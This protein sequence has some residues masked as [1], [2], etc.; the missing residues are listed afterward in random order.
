[1]RR[2]AA[3]EYFNLMGGRDDKSDAIEMPPTKFQ[4][5]INMFVERDSLIKRGGYSKRNAAAL[6]GGNAFQAIHEFEDNT[7]SSA[8]IYAV[9]GNLFRDDL[10][11]S[12][13]TD[14]TGGLSLAG[15]Q[16]AQYQ[17]ITYDGEV[18]GTDQTNPL[19]FI[20]SLTSNAASI[21]VGGEAMPTKCGALGLYYQY[22]LAGDVT[23]AEDGV[24]YPYRVR[25][26]NPP[27][28]TDWPH[29]RFVDLN[30]NQKIVGFRMHGEYMIIFQERMMWSVQLSSQ[31][32]STVLQTEFDFKPL[33][34][35]IGALSDKAIVST[36]KGL[37]WLD[38]K[39][40]YYLPAG[41]LQDPIYV[42]KPN[43]TFWS[44]LNASRLGYVCG[45]E[46]KEQNG[47]VFGVPYGSAQ[48]T[49]NRGIFLNYE[50]WSRVGRQAHPAYTIFEGTDDQIFAFNVLARAQVSGRD[51]LIGGGYD[52]FA[53]TLQ[54]TT[55]DDGEGIQAEIRTPFYAPQG[56]A[57]ESV[58]YQLALDIDLFGSKT[59]TVEYTLYN[60]QTPRTVTTSAGNE[61]ALLGNTFILGQSKLSRDDLGRL[62]LDLDGRSRYIELRFTIGADQLNF[63]LH[64]IL[65]YYKPVNF[66]P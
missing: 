20:E 45:A 1:M 6:A 22:I 8:L 54:D 42:G 38:R 21:P 27:F 35:Q 59:V 40:V 12:A 66:Y 5:I 43:E 52:G 61:G 63:A 58:W 47:V 34:P 3:K 24:R 60:D 53:Y 64:G 18:I 25:W 7:Q 28:I 14:I 57:R 37:F 26:H 44:Q 9:N 19:F 2:V 11:G 39:G 55:Q 50:E 49:N 15:G 16:D 29:D 17:F 32:T 33:H 4:E 31:A 62:M 30:R 65:L 36:E 51:R 13:P 46:L 23:E 56:R 10:D 48:T 41:R